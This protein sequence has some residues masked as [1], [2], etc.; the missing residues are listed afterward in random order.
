MAIYGKSGNTVKKLEPRVKHNGVIK[1]PV[2]GWTKQN[3]V[4]KKI[5][6]AFVPITSMSINGPARVDMPSAY[7]DVQYTCNIL[8][9]N[10]TNKNVTWS[11]ETNEAYP[12]EMGDLSITSDGLV[13]FHVS[14]AY[15]GG[16]VYTATIKAT[17]Q[18]GSGKSAQI[19]VEVY[20]G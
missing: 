12:G 3:G 1:T 11:W 14:P 2:S 13:T 17:A 20:Y 9:A 18:D 15:Y 10:A 4:L 6:Q 16:Y 5:W 8:P 19:D 7:H